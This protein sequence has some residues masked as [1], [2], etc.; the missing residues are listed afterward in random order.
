MHTG[1]G[2]CAAGPGNAGFRKDVGSLPTSLPPCVP[3]PGKFESCWLAADTVLVQPRS[4]AT[5]RSLVTA[6]VVLATA[7]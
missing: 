1:K 3:L 5:A 2:L 7:A 6:L 4:L